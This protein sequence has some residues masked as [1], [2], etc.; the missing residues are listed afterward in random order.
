MVNP[1][2]KYKRVP[3]ITNIVVFFIIAYFTR[4]EGLGL[5]VFFAVLFLINYICTFG[6]TWMRGYWDAKIE[7][8]DEE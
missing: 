6:I 8:E 2:D 1:Y 4:E 5:V 3:L 7:K